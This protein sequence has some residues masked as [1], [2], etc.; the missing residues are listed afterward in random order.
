MDVVLPL[1]FHN[2]ETHIVSSYI[3][4]SSQVSHFCLVKAKH[5]S[6]QHNFNIMSN[7]R[8]SGLA[9]VIKVNKSLLSASYIG[10]YVKENYRL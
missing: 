3:Y 4:T 8:T 2:R 6:I 10:P 1:L 9:S 5:I 7:V